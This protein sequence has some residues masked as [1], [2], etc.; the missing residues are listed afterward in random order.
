MPTVQC[1]N[2]QNSTYERQFEQGLK[3][4]LDLEKS[5]DILFIA[6]T[7]LIP[8]CFSDPFNID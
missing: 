8:K 6:R 3:S 5:S 7:R 4:N 1:Y 2:T